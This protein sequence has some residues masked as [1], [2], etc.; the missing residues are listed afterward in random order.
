MSSVR[1]FFFVQEAC[2]G[3]APSVHPSPCVCLGLR[4]QSS[5]GPVLE[6]I[7]FNPVWR[8]PLS[9]AREARNTLSSLQ[10][11]VTSS[12]IRDTWELMCPLL[13][14]A[15]RVAS[16]AAHI[17][18]DRACRCLQYETCIGLMQAGDCPVPQ[19]S[20]VPPTTRTRHT[21]DKKHVLSACPRRMSQ[22]RLSILPRRKASGSAPRSS[23]PRSHIARPRTWV[24]VR[25]LF[26]LGVSGAVSHQIHSR[27]C[28]KNN[29]VWEGRRRRYWWSDPHDAAN[30]SG[31]LGLHPLFFI[32]TWFLQRRCLCVHP[33]CGTLQMFE[34]V[35]LLHQ[36]GGVIMVPCLH[37]F[38]LQHNKRSSC[39]S[40]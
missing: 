36:S 8:K 14:K 22:I 32:Q 38:V 1:W 30:I 10:H 31:G 40:V 29:E 3:V 9:Q 23:S 39:Q 17:R 37:V 4:M 33:Q 6:R 27:A 18:C 35:C 19:S 24:Q 25:M 15:Q 2:V 34:H 11:I 21:R 16:V 26:D 20:T 28:G 5:K 13:S 12:D 7:R